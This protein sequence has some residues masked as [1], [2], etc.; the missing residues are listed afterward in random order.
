MDGNQLGFSVRDVSV[1][2]KITAAAPPSGRSGRD[3]SG[4]TSPPDW[5]TDICQRGSRGAPLVECW[6][7]ECV[8]GNRTDRRSLWENNENLCQH[9]KRFSG[10][11]PAAG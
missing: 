2:H 5:R 11:S 9:G 8:Q 7:D 1:L 10:P 4:R 6:N 3:F